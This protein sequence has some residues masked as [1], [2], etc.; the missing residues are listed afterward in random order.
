ML[1][2]I[3]F[4]M[5]ATSNFMWSQQW[6]MCWF[7]FFSSVNQS[8]CWSTILFREWWLTSAI[9]PFFVFPFYGNTIPCLC[10]CLL[11]LY[12]VAT[13]DYFCK[14]L[15]KWNWP[16]VYGT[17]VYTLYYEPD[18]CMSL[19]LL[20]RKYSEYDSYGVRNWSGCAYT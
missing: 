15:G 19:S 2:V 13:N 20:S 17:L 4:H 7:W 6:I 3:N 10:A 14:F 9:S 18:P 12:L 1:H 11:P 5:H 16:S 8:V